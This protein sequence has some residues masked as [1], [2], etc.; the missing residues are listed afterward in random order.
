MKY[1]IFHNKGKVV[2]TTG[3]ELIYNENEPNDLDNA[4]NIHILERIHSKN[5]ENAAC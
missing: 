3:L 2:N 1:I 5:P 4:N